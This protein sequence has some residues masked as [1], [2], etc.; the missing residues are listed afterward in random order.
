MKTKMEQ[1]SIMIREA[2]KQNDKVARAYWMGVKDAADGIQLNYD[3][4][5]LVK[6]D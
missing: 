1:A 4:C 5:V 2:E 3:R 6:G